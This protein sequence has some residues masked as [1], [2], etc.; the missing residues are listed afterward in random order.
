[1]RTRRPHRADQ[2]L[3]GTA[4]R[5]VAAVIAALL[6]TTFGAVAGPAQA[7][8]TPAPAPVP[9]PESVVDAAPQPAAEIAEVPA[10]DRD[11]VLP[12]GWRSSADLAWTTSGDSRGFHLLVAEERTGYT[13]RTV[14]SLSEPTISS[15]QWIGRACLTASGRRA[16]VVYQ[17]RH[18]TNRSH[19]FDRGAFAAVVEIG[20][21][22]V[23]KLGLNVSI[24]YYNP[25]CGNG[26]TAV[27]TQGGASDLGRT[28]VHLVDTVRGTVVRRQQL[29][30]QV[31]SA[32]PYGANLAAAE[33]GRIFRL[34]RDGSR[35]TLATTR[36]VAAYLRPDSAG[37]LTWLEAADDETTLARRVQDGQVRELARG[38]LTGIGLDRGTDGQVFLTGEPTSTGSLP[39]AVRRVAVPTST[40]LS[41]HGHLALRRAP[42]TNGTAAAVPPTGEASGLPVALRA[43]VLGTGKQVDFR[44]AL[45]ARASRKADGGRRI[46]PQV[47]RAHRADGGLRAQASGSPTDPVEPDRYCSVPRNDVRTQVEQPHWRQVEWAAN[48][49]VQGALTVQRPANWR[50]SGLPA[51]SPQGMLP[52]IPLAGGGRV[53]AQVM[54]GIL[55]QES[56]LWQASWHALEGVPGNPLVGNY[57]GIADEQGWDIDW[58]DADCGYGV[59]QVTDGMRMAGRGKP[60]EVIRPANEQRA[61]AVDYAT[62]IAASLRILQD[63]WNQTYNLGIRMNDADPANPEN[64]WAAIWAYNTGLNP[65]AITGGTGC[66]PGPNCTDDRGNW[67]LGWSQN[68]ANPEYPY[69]RTPFLDGDNGNGSPGDAAHPGDWSY[70]EKVMGWAAYPIVKYDFRTPNEYH[71]GYLQAWWVDPLHRTQSIKP[72]LGTF[73]TSANNC[74]VTS[75]STSCGYS[76]YHCWWHWPVDWKSGCQV[77]CGYENIRFSPGSAEPARGTHYPPRC[78]V[79]GLPA[80]A[81][82]VDDQPSSVGIVRSDACPTP[83]TNNGTFSLQFSGNASGLYPSKADFHQIG[84]GLNGHFWFAHEQNAASEQTDRLKVT[85]TWRLGR[86]L[87]QWA[88]V[89]V[90]MPSHGAHSQQAHYTVD[91]GANITSK[92]HKTRVVGQRQ[93][94]NRWVPLGTFQFN[95]VPQVSLSNIT[96]G[97][98]V[99]VENVAWDAVAIVPLSQKP[100]NFVVAL[101]ESY[102]SGEGAATDAST[103]YYHDSNH[104]GGGVLEHRN[105]CHRSQHAWSRQ[106]WLRD[107][108]QQR[109]IGARSDAFDP[110]MDY[111][112]IACSGARTH[113]LL[114]S[115]SN[116]ISGVQ[117]SDPLTGAPFQ[118]A[119]GTTARQQAREVSQLDKGF[120]DE[121]TTLVTL[122]VGGNDVEWSAAIENCILLPIPCQE[123]DIDGH[124]AADYLPRLMDREGRQ[125]IATVLRAIRVMAPNAQIMLM[126]YP[127]L[128][129]NDA[130][131]V[132]WLGYGIS[133]SEAAWT[134][135]LAVELR[136]VLSEVAIA[137]NSSLG[138]VRFV[139]PIINGDFAG[140]GVCG[141]PETI[142]GIVAAKTAGEDHSKVQNPSQQSFHPKI[143]GAA[144]YARS[145]NREFRNIGL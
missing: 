106:A 116:P 20:T 145:L 90:H 144:N 7:A 64:W 46:D 111:H 45:G 25:G 94:T 76:D 83:V 104:N 61:I 125:S 139:D 67:G 56:N 124:R 128:F 66:S 22:K 115:G 41:T 134:N 37:G 97:V 38:P 86:S 43:E 129:S 18:F 135:Q 136:D 131:C 28:R 55:A 53:P 102:S 27:L 4:R 100:R 112:L 75:T 58:T 39:P 138:R 141:E 65:Q 93:G 73:C 8:P 126:G 2:T 133:D 10:G 68:I 59:G 89:Y 62:N 48:L 63:K 113:N 118:T 79:S 71:A 80:G 29:S 105:G 84:S 33:G 74:S 82:I 69:T 95:G 34:D 23:T 137:A 127:Q 87:N 132:E 81:L 13:W 14:A 122:S 44:V 51:W 88:R 99:G 35:H 114:P 101:G 9:A 85:G 121:N 21:G 12:K 50:Q 1:M 110:T 30:G 3:D 60:G 11:T 103:D 24:A 98:D 70:P 119:W 123:S 77:A 52:P 120:V 36:G 47:A 15:E 42:V 130:N 117:V 5:R 31:T 49:A 17:P 140:Q 40:E 57:Y 108:P 26:E 109:S 6:T 54:L 16:V 92:R 72:P 91:R 19:L 96:R 142:H 143:S 32:V 107:D 78:A